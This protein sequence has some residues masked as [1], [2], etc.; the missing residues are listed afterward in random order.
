VID[1]TGRVEEHI[2]VARSVA[3]LDDAA[4]TALRQWT[5]TPGRDHDGHTVR[6]QIEV[7]IRFQLR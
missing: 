4:V 7:P 6:V 5:F 1:R 2:V 3:Q